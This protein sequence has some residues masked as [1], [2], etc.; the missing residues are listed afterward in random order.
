MR[1]VSA[2]TAV[3]IATGYVTGIDVQRRFVDKVGSGRIRVGIGWN[4]KA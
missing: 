3:D 2:S 4:R 1:R